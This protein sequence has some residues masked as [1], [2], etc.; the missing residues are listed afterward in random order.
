MRKLSMLLVIALILLLAAAPAAA[1]SPPLN[2]VFE[3]VT[4]FP[5]EGPT[6]GPFTASG[7]A[8]DAG[9][10]C[11][12]GDTIDTFG[13]ASGYQSQTGVNFQVIKLFA[14]DDGSGEFYVK[15]QVRIDAKGDNFRWTIVD[16]SGAYEKLHGTGSGI[17]LPIPDG[18]FDIYDGKLHLD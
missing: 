12:S 2:V 15:L 17:G 4:L 16:G 10:V 18:V 9:I 5:P 3:V 6:Y 7:P 11:P 1:S 13:K 8:V 14:C